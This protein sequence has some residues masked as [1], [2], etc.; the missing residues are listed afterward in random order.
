MLLD[1]NRDLK[2]VDFGLSTK[3]PDDNLLDQ[4]CGTVVYAAP[5]VL[6]G[7]EYHG[8]LADVWS[9]GIVLYGMLS[10]YLPFGEQND[11]INRLNIIAGKINYPNYFSACVK[12]LLMHM[13]DLDPMTR[14]TLQ[15]V[16]SHPWFNSID[17]KLIPGIII[18]YNLI[19][20]DE[21]I[22]DLCVAYNCDRNKVKESV[23]NNKYNSESALY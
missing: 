6:Q 1:R 17:Y 14:Y 20:V 22:L 23:I 12:D 4:P 10:G 9:S 7:R 19:P 11:E 5:E 2:L 18:G 13:L 15:E 3:Y 8:M 21:K 16:R